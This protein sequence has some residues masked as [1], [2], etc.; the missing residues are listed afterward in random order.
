[1]ED[2][3]PKCITSCEKLSA[4][5]GLTHQLE[6]RSPI[7]LMKSSRKW[8]PLFTAFIVS[9]TNG[10]IVVSS[11]DYDTDISFGTTTSLPIRVNLAL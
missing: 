4:K 2:A 9:T 11:S 7:Y 3:D 1:M 10:A 6:K 8:L 5:F